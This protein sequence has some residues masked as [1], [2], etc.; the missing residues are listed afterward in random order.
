MKVNKKKLTNFKKLIKEWN[1][2]RNNSLKP[3]QFTCGSGKKV[4][5]I[6]EYKHEW[7]S[8][9]KTRTRGSNCPTC[10]G[11]KVNLKNNLQITR[12]KLSKLWNYNKNKFSAA[13]YLPSSKE[14]VWWTCYEGHEY[15]KRIVNM[16]RLRRTP[17]CPYCPKK[18]DD[19]KKLFM[20]F[21][22][23]KQE[24]HDEYNA[25]ICKEN[26]SYGSKQKV[27]WTCPKGHEYEA[28]ILKR[29]TRNQ[30]CPYCSGRRANKENSLKYLFPR[31]A[32]EWDKTKNKHNLPEHF[33][34]GSSFKAWWK[35]KKN[36]S[37]LTRICNRT[38]KNGTNCPYCSN[39]KVS[40]ENN[41]LVRF[42]ELAKEW[43]PYKNGELLP[44]DLLPASRK[45]VWWLCSEGH[46]YSSV[47]SMR[48]SSMKTNC[49]YCARQRASSKYNLAVKFPE[50]IKEWDYKKNKINPNEHLPG[51]K[52]KAWWLCHEGHSYYSRISDR[53][54]NKSGCPYCSGTLVSDKNSLKIHYPHLLKEWD[55]NKNKKIE[56][57]NISYGS[58]KKV[59]WKCKNNHSYEA[60]V[61]SRTTKKSGCPVCT[62]Q[63]SKPELRIFSEMKFLFKDTIS[64][65]K[66]ENYEIDIF[67]PSKKIGIEY[68]GSYFHKSTFDKDLIKNSICEKNNITLIRIREEPL[69]RL[70][71][72]DILIK[73][74]TL[75]A[76]STLDLVISQIEKICD[77]IDKIKIEHYKSKKNFANEKLY[78]SLLNNLPS[79]F[80]DNSLKVTHSELC[81]EW[82]YKKNYPLKPE[83]FTYGSKQYVWWICSRGHS[84]DMQIT[85]RTIKKK[86]GCPFCSGK[87]IDITNSLE[88]IHPL[89]SQEW[90]YKKNKNLLPS[91]VTR[92]SSKK[93]W[94]VCK[95]NH[96]WEATIKSRTL[97]KG[98]CPYC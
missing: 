85:N 64:R 75:I 39:K 83:N 61:N 18:I 89:V 14:I 97:R 12:P 98:R 15:Q 26:I 41:L 51:S 82:D 4:W 73:Y 5:W 38:K 3:E 33:T 20:L 6:C 16:S 86:Q 87:R 17:S 37:Y 93:V 35:C 70:S 80:I 63:S 36:H 28:Q 94:W 96:E 68:D 27:W 71:P 48:T 79:P 58:S 59:W 50:I 92:A 60:V 23:L 43:H 91:N 10:M 13:D 45:V 52:K 77:D 1:Y 22:N 30:G 72:N 31:I 55:Y 44:K 81:D 88:S 11:K 95:N 56:P 34:S 2:E 57:T 67:V 8:E 19:S 49:P 65:Y 9:I 76:K 74:E 90:N 32:N 29:T 78:K 24:W 46:S 25:N 62:F 40:S 7:L 42:P 69:R 53:T 84:Y 54:L 47:A 21:P 66:I